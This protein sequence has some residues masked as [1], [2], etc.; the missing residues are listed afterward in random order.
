MGQ[1]PKRNGEPIPELEPVASGS[2]DS[3]PNEASGSSGDPSSLP[4]GTSQNWMYK[5]KCD[6]LAF[7]PDLVAEQLTMMDAELFKKVV[8]YHCLG[9]IWSKS[10]KKVKE[11]LAPTIWANITH[12][13]NVS[14][15]VIT[16]CLGDHSM[17][18]PDR[19]L[20]VEHWIHVAWECR[21][22]RNFSSLFAIISAL[23]SSSIH[24]LERTWEQ[25]SRDSFRR[26]QK[27]S[28]IISPENNHSR[29]RELLFKEDS[30]F[31][32]KEKKAKRGQRQSKEVVMVKDTIPYLGIFL[33]DLVMIDAAFQDFLDE[34]VI[35]FQKL[36]KE[37]DVMEQVR[38]LQATCNYYNILPEEHFIAWFK[39]LE[40]L[41]EKASYDLSRALEPRTQTSSKNLNA[42]KRLG[43]G[44]AWKSRQAQRTD[45]NSSGSSQSMP[46]D[47]AKCGPD[48][49]RGDIPDSN[50]KPAGA[51]SSDLK[52]NSSLIK[53]SSDVLEKVRGRALPSAPGI[54]ETSL[55]STT[56]F[57]PSA[58]TKS[59]AVRGSNIKSPGSEVKSNSSSMPLYNKQRGDACIIRVSLQEDTGNVYKSILVTNQE[60]TQEIILKAMK[61]HV[62]HGYKPE[63]LE[64]VQIISEDRKLRIPGDA[65]LFYAMNSMA[66]YNFM[67]Q[68]STYSL[69]Q[70]S[71]ME[72]VPPSMKRK[73]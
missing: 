65:N 5:E 23:Q 26:F 15:C 13:N 25:V 42:K 59:G 67:L 21:V 10:D 57:R 60:K 27:L 43:I 49:S 68:K 20:V 53:K 31:A 6:F 4:C 3:E 38:Q 36:R 63:H 28:E 58:S 50:I 73:D 11:H 35:N 8:P 45:L 47:L 66:K 71:S 69:E 29:F 19:R 40:R 46:L 37:Y 9:S 41:S 32:S 51:S 48:N 24:R 55:S 1:E 33:K 56:T 7:P 14:S 39:G 18:A 72:P 52:L 16:S 2:I 12:F 22:L 70:Q 44:K 34:G 64:L 17:T 54:S 61:K 62:L 30:K